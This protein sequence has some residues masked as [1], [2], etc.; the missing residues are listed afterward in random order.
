VA[1]QKE[2]QDSARHPK[3][4]NQVVVNPAGIQEEGGT[5]LESMD[6]ESNMDFV[7]SSLLFDEFDNKDEK[8]DSDLEVEG[9]EK[10]ET[11][12][13]ASLPTSLKD[14]LSDLAKAIDIDGSNISKFN[15]C[16]M[17]C[18]RVQKGD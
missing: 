17:T 15:I 16:K 4:Q 9:V 8:S 13:S 12:V 2:L 18:G 5:N 14:S 1:D 7:Y 3:P 11:Q 6:Q 10:A